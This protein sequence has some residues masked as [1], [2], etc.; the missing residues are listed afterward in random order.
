MRKKIIKF[1]AKITPTFLKKIGKKII[2]ILED[3]MFEYTKDDI[4]GEMLRGELNW[5]FLRAKEMNEVVEIGSWQGRSTH[6]L[7][8]GCKGTVYAIDH[9]KGS[10]TAEGQCTPLKASQENIFQKFMDNVG[11]FKNL[12]VYRM[13]SLEAAK[14]FFNDKSIDMVFI[15]GDHSYKAVKADIEAWLPKVKKLIC[16][17][18][19]NS[20]SPGVKQA[21]NEKFGSVKTIYGIWFHYL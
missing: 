12:K 6:A 10:K 18:D 16:G 2:K 9:F 5:L 17:H 11:H 20:S 19:Y 3:R 21:V 1:L 7:L 13:S 14:K 15:D 4:S 8:S